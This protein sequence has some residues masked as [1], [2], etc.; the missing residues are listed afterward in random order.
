MKRAVTIGK[1][2]I[3]LA[4]ASFAMLLAASPRPAR[5]D[6]VYTYTGN[7]FTSVSGSYNTTDSLD[8]S[9][10]F[11][12]ALASDL[13]D[14]ELY[15]TSFTFSDGVQTITNSTATNSVY[16]E[17]STDAAGI[18]D[19]WYMYFPNPGSGNYIETIANS[20]GSLTED[21]GS[22]SSVVAYDENN[23]GTWTESPV[24]APEPSSLAII[25]VGM[26][27]LGLFCRRRPNRL[28]EPM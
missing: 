1:N 2:L 18:I 11:T 19:S 14:A 23:P 16:I 10:T 25:A 5:A 22:T 26:S 21:V 6:V 20:Q 8:G 3:G 15:P 27:V 4:G 13:D 24:A 12:T 9:M 28:P 7:D 17:V